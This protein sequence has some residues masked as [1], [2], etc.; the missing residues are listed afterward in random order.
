MKLFFFHHTASSLVISGFLLFITCPFSAQSAGRDRVSPVV[1]AE[2]VKQNSSKSGIIILHIAST[3]RDYENGHI[4]GARFLWPGHIIKSTETES[5]IPATP[6]DAEKKLRELGVNN[7]SHII[8]CGIY[9][10]IIQVCRVFVNLEHY[11][12]RGRVSVL[13][14]GYEAW[15]NS[16]YESSVYVPVPAK[17]K[18]KITLYE[19][20]VEGGFVK[21][22]LRDSTFTII[23]ARSKAQYEGTTGTPR[24]GHIPGAKNLPQMDSYDGRTF[25]F[26]DANSIKAAFEKINI[27][28]GSRPLVY[29]HTGN[30]ASVDYVAALI[31]GYEP[32]LYD[33]SMEEWGSRFDWPVEKE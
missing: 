12:L 24:T 21:S 19:N 5:T 20:L 26:Y 30:S 28:S 14:G 32:W 13:N 31:A 15:L 18:F 9:G 1:T 3:K 16:G 25:M 6:V 22:I 17:G 7:D 33:G 29:C 8:L 2:W 11:G 10:N 23:D 4:P 27:P